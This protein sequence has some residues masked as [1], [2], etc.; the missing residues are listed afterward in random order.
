LRNG[1]LKRAKEI[2]LPYSL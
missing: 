2:A 1:G